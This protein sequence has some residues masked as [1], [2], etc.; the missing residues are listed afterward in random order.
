MLAQEIELSILM[1]IGFVT[2]R[3]LAGCGAGVERNGPHA[4]GRNSGTVG[5]MM[6]PLA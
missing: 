4:S 3:A 5:K 1:T 6:H 2:I